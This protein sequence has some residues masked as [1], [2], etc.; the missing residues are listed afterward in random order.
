MIDTDN[1]YK[2]LGALRQ[3]GPDE[4]LMIA[5]GLRVA[6]EVHQW[7]LFL[8][9]VM[10]TEDRLQ[11]LF[12]SARKVKQVIPFSTRSGWLAIRCPSV[13]PEDETAVSVAKLRQVVEELGISID[14]S[15]G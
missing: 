9:Q 1:F 6:C 10:N 14:S 15:Y 11:A 2:S 12:N 8:E 5:E 13:V 7:T 4:Q 3:I